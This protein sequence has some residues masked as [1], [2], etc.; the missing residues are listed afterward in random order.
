MDLRK[1]LLII[2]NLN[3]IKEKEKQEQLRK[4]RE[5]ADKKDQERLQKEKLAKER[6]EKE[7][8]ENEREEKENVDIRNLIKGKILEK[9]N[10]NWNVIALKNLKDFEK[11]VVTLEVLLNPRGEIIG[12]IKVVKPKKVYGNFVLAKRVA[13]NA[14]IDSAP[15]KIPES[16]FPTGL[17]LQITFDPRTKEQLLQQSKENRFDD[18]LAYTWSCWFP[19]NSHPCGKCPMCKERVLPHPDNLMENNYSSIFNLWS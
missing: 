5:L 11:Y 12:P 9:V 15:F 14:I 1:E 3:L 17:N 18:I 8:R 16:I 7:A 6:K 10:N 4:E 13:T 2:A 19:K